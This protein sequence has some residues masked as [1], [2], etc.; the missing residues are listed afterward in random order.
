MG[1][2]ARGFFKVILFPLIAFWAFALLIKFTPFFK[3]VDTDKM[4]EDSINGLISYYKV[5]APFQ[6]LIAI[7]TQWLVVM[8]LW[9]KILAKPKSAI[10]I[11]TVML[12]ICLL[13][14]FG[15]A[16]IIWD[17]ITKQA[18]LMHIFLFM[19]GVQLFYWVINFALLYLMDHN[20]FKPVA[21]TED[22]ETDS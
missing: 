8:P 11:F 18:H 14:A 12:L 1:R 13:A 5:F 22:E 4:G 19:A 3:Y 10:T 9:R 6:I 21:V 16:Y 17:P 2:F 20:N 7:L 15:I